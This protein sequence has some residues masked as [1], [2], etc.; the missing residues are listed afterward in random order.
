MFL[1]LASR[2]KSRML[3]LGKYI[4]VQEP[5]LGYNPINHRLHRVPRP[6]LWQMTRGN[7]IYARNL[8]PQPATTSL[9]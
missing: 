7:D 6:S 8:F 4:L 2:R 9:A 1:S 5:L 3:S